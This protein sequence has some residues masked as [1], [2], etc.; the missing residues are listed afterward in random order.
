[1]KKAIIVILLTLY[2][3]LVVWSFHTYDNRDYYDAFFVTILFICG[4][5][6]ACIV[7]KKIMDFLFWLID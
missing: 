1:M 2:F 3:L 4:W 6:I 7:F 5:L